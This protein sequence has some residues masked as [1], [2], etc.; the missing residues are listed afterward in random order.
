MVPKF[1]PLAAINTVTP[2]NSTH[3]GS[4]GMLFK[5]CADLFAAL[6][7]E[8]CFLDKLQEKQRLAFR[9][10]FG[11]FY[12]GGTGFLAEQGELDKTLDISARLKD[13]TIS[14]LVQIAKILCSEETGELIATVRISLAC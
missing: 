6:T 12:F 2:S 1:R 14:L 8:A 9:E 4:A 7:K 13:Q 3:H 10:M 5:S 11:K